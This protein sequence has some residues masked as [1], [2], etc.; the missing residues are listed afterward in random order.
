MAKGTPR[1]DVIASRDQRVPLRRRMG[2]GW[3]VAYAALYLYSDEAGFVTGVS[4]AVDG[5]EGVSWGS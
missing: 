1:E 4:L 3:D 5:G 2:T